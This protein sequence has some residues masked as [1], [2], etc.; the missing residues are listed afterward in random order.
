VKEIKINPKK[1]LIFDL[2]VREMC[3]SCKRY[4]K[5]ATCPPHVESF[6]YYEK[7]LPQFKNGIIYYKKFNVGNRKNWIKKGK[8][9]SLEIYEKIIYE[10][11]RLI[12]I[13][14]HYFFIGFGAGSCKLCDKCTFPCKNPGRS[15][16]PFEATGVDRVRIMENLGVK[17]NVPIKKYF[18]RI[19]ALFYD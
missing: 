17:I 15:L 7:L 19:G 13:R 12:T 2:K 6:E 11:D 10:R 9:S 3:K 8:Q 14:G 5:K 18:Y 1:D 16:I 4:G